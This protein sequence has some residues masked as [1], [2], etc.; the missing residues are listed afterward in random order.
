MEGASAE[1]T[2]NLEEM[3]WIEQSSVIIYYRLGLEIIYIYIYKYIYIYICM[4]VCMYDNKC[5]C[6]NKMDFFLISNKID[7]SG[8]IILVLLL[9]L[10]TLSFHK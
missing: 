9:F 8:W 4:Y 10:F 1:N 2:C 5:N 3:A 6:I 7:F